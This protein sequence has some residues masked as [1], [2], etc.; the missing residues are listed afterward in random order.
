MLGMKIQAKHFYTFL[1]IRR[2]ITGKMWAVE[3]EWF[4]ILTETDGCE[5]QPTSRKTVPGDLPTHDLNV[6]S[7]L[8]SPNPCAW[9][10]PT[11][12]LSAFSPAC[13]GHHTWLGGCAGVV[14]FGSPSAIL[15]LWVAMRTVSRSVSS[16]AA[17]PWWGLQESMAIALV[18]PLPLC[19]RH[20]DASLPIWSILP[21]SHAMDTN[22]SCSF[23]GFALPKH[24]SFPVV[25][26]QMSLF[27]QSFSSVIRMCSHTG[28]ICLCQQVQGLWSCCSDVA[29]ATPGLAFCLLHLFT[30]SWGTAQFYSIPHHARPDLS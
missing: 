15:L 22:Q 23:D 29:T 19:S 21:C 5:S 25:S 27:S 18:L 28:G 13:L 1:A 8:S 17:Q 10:C 24:V 16:S 14:W 30:F 12:L 6:R 3:V 20:L 9:P 11:L 4:S 2:G 7:R 26:L